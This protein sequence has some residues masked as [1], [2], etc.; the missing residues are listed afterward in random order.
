VR[1]YFTDLYVPG[2]DGGYDVDRYPTYGEHWRGSGR[3][4][5]ERLDAL[6]AHEAATAEEAAVRT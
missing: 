1:G 2:W 4:W 3:W 5:L 6:G